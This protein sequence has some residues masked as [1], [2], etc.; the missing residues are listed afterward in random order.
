MVI[1]EENEEAASSSIHNLQSLKKNDRPRT[2][3]GGHEK[4]A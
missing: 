3:A 1:G 4:I 2:S